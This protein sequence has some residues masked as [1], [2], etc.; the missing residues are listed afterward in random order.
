MIK[1]RNAVSHEPQTRH[2]IY[3]WKYLEN[4]F[5]DDREIVIT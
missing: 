1:W 3:A 5:P 4:A 2:V